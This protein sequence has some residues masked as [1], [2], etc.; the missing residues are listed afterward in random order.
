MSVFSKNFVIFWLIGFMLM[1]PAFAE[2]PMIDLKQIAE[3]LHYPVEHLILENYLEA[4]QL[5]YSIKG[6]KELEYNKPTPFPPENIYAAYKI[7]SD[8]PSS[9]HPIKITIV[10]RNSYRTKKFDEIEQGL[11]KNV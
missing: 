2:K 8:I 5:I 6:M 9:F 10:K 1:S 3:L 7:S 11:R 4:E